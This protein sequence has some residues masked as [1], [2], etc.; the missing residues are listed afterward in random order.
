MGAPLPKDNWAGIAIAEAIDG[1][2][3]DTLRL[4]PDTEVADIVYALFRNLAMRAEAADL[5]VADVTVA[6]QRYTRGRMH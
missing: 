4:Y 5:G 6:W 3:A 1:S 2:I